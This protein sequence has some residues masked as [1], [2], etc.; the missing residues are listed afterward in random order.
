[1]F[2]CKTLCK[3]GGNIMSHIIAFLLGVNFATKESSTVVDNPFPFCVSADDVGFVF[4]ILTLILTPVLFLLIL[5]S[6]EK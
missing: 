2:R 3:I 1:M 5:F 4:Y 6:D